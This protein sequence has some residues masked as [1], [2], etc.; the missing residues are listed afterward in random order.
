MHN[1]I[2]FN[3]FSMLKMKIH[4]AEEF[5]SMSIEAITRYFENLHKENSKD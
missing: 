2:T 1:L 5:K 4:T 3:A